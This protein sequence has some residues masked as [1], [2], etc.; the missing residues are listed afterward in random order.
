MK[1]EELLR[2]VR[3]CL[4]D[5]ESGL[6]TLFMR[7]LSSRANN[8]E[9]FKKVVTLFLNAWQKLWDPFRYK[10][11]PNSCV[12]D[13]E[14]TSLLL[15]APAANLYNCTIAF[16]GEKGR[17]LL[18][19]AKV[20]RG[21][22][23]LREAPFLKAIASSSSVSLAFDDIDENDSLMSFLLAEHVS[24]AWEMGLTMYSNGESMIND[25]AN[26][27]KYQKFLSEMQSHIFIEDDN[28]W[29]PSDDRT[30]QWSIVQII[31]MMSTASLCTLVS[32]EGCATAASMVDLCICIF[33]ILI[34]LPTNCHSMSSVVGSSKNVNTVNHNDGNK[35]KTLSVEEQR[36]NI[37]LF[38]QASA[39]NHSCA[40]NA[41]YRYVSKDCLELVSLSDIAANTE[42]SISY[43][44][45]GGVHTLQN[46]QKILLHQYLF[47]CKCN[48]C[49]EETLGTMNAGN[50]QD[51]TYGFDDISDDR[52]EC[53]KLY[54][55]AED[56]E[57]YDLEPMLSKIQYSF[58]KATSKR[59]I[60]F[61]CEAL[62][63]VARG[64]AD[65]GNFQTAAPLVMEAIKHLVSSQVLDNNDVAVAR[66][67]VKAA[68]LYAQFDTQQATELA[69][70][71]IDTLSITCS[72]EDIDL[73]EARKIAQGL[74]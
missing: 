1:S 7:T 51:N 5:R 59:H 10:M 57:D 37:S 50:K 29:I 74:A 6:L 9:D 31:F 32:N 64:Y 63:K 30:D 56:T 40:P 67:R 41:T 20:N 72:A 36:V 35:L 12:K 34:R 2:F 66:E 23:L 70:Q 25:V 21:E 73:I 11:H 22:I 28:V 68:G 55:K 49:I 65:E 18:T 42:V 24:M 26:K 45:M 61:L 60:L 8:R 69:I 15:N 44:P 4:L 16:D 53:I 33:E 38:M 71:A 43:G 58:L 14:G 27:K 48:V 62:D 52:M 19:T 47:T 3:Q 39:V 13:E 17:K 46:R 54:M